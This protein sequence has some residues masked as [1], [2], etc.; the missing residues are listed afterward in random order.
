MENADLPQNKPVLIILFD[1]NCE[2]CQRETE[3]ILKNI[4]SLSNIQIVMATNASFADLKKF[5]QSYQL[6]RVENIVAGVEPKYFLASFFA[7][8]N[9]PYLAM[10]DN[11]GRLL[12]THEGNMK[13]SNILKVYH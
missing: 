4:D 13:I 12:T 1:P 6:N 9:L 11:K 2:H 3:E 10:Y 7:I 8:R 5:Y